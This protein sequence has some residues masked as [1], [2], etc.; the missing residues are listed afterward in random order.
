MIVKREVFVCE[1]N[2][3]SHNIVLELF[4]WGDGVDFYINVYVLQY[5][6]FFKRIWIGIK[7]IFGMKYLYGH[8]DTIMIKYEDVPRLRSLLDE[9]EKFE[10]RRLNS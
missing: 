5:N 7:Y 4:D 1:C 3:I 9:Y 2:D 8:Y 10:N 6:G